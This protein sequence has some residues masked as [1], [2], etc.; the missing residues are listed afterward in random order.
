MLPPAL[1]FMTTAWIKSTTT[2]KMATST[3]LTQGLVKGFSSVPGASC[4]A[5]EE[6]QEEFLKRYKQNLHVQP[7]A[8]LCSRTVANL[9]FTY[10]SWGA[11]ILR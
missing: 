6:L 10:R 1:F 9:K 7:N 4:Q 2:A 5:G 3:G 11:I 8:A